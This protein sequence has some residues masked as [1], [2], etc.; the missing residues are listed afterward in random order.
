MQFE[1]FKLNVVEHSSP[2]LP[3]SVPHQSSF[4]SD[5]RRKCGIFMLGVV[6]Y[7]VNF[8]MLTTRF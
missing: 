6:F 7:S 8:D 1:N 4:C 2:R 5:F 3:A